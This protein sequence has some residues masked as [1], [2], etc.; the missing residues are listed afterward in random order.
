MKYVK[1]LANLSKVTVR[2]KE[3]LEVSEIRNRHANLKVRGVVEKGY[4][5]KSLLAQLFNT[6]FLDIPFHENDFESAHRAYALMPP[7]PTDFIVR[8]THFGLK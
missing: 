3:K 4:V 6:W 1:S 2:L 7:R 5:V 8:L